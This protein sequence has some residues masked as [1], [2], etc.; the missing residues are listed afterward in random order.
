ME[1]K[2]VSP[3]NF[4]SEESLFTSEGLLNAEGIA[5]NNAILEKEFQNLDALFETRI[6]D[7][8][9]TEEIFNEWETIPAGDGPFSHMVRNLKIS[10]IEKVLLLLALE[11]HYYPIVV[12]DRLARI[13]EKHKSLIASFAYYKDP[14]SHGYY[15]TLQ[16]VL[17]LCAGKNTAGWRN[18]EQE[19]LHH[20]KLFKE[21]IILLRDP[22]ERGRICNRLNYLLDLAPEYVEYFLHGQKPRPDFGRAFPAKWVTTKMDWDHLVLNKL[23]IGEINDVMD[24][25][26]HGQDVLTRSKNTVNRSFPCLFYG[27]PGTGKSFTAKLIGKHY[28]KDVF[29]IDLSMIVSKYI[30]ETE[31][32]LAHLFDRAEGK[33]WILFFDEADALFGKRTGISDSKDKWANLEMSYLLQRME[34]YPGLCILATNLKHNL[35]PAMTRRFQSIIYFPWPKP[36]ER[37]LIWQKSLPP[38]FTYPDNISFEKLS[39]YDFSGAG[40]ANVIKS[41]CVKAAKR[42]DYI[43]NV[44]DISRFI[45]IEYA[46]ENRTPAATAATQKN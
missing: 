33:D 16:T 31:K 40:I 29:R 21:Q 26:A 27:P 42:G 38:G 41:S 22:D 32:N 45:R 10:H 11:S 44:R 8:N 2:P 17:F 14:F 28:G 23:T 34:E 1:S 46:K 9:T 43:L 19:I 24:W 37:E 30:G 35:D 20:G 12:A 4:F 5:T 25:V 36:E 18:A 15:P 7:A 39:Q 6:L 3:E 13:K